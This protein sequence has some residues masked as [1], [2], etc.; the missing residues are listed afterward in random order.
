VYNAHTH[1]QYTHTHWYTVQC[2][3]SR[4]HTHRHTVQCTHAHTG[5]LCNTHTL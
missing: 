3:H 4:T 1:A 2:T 5:T